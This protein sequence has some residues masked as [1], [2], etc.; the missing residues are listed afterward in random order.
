MSYLAE[1][2]PSIW[3][4]LY[5]PPRFHVPFY[6]DQFAMINMDPNMLQHAGDAA[7][8]TFTVVVNCTCSFNVATVTAVQV[9][10]VM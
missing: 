10:A 5:F 2:R 3:L 1:N 6:Q 9:K 8:M 7:V 4:P